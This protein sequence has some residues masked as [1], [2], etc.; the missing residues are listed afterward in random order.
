MFAQLLDVRDQIPRR[1][2]FDGS[3]RRALPRAPLIEEHDAIGRWVVKLPI[4]R[5]H[6]P[7]GST[8]QEHYRL[9]LRIAALLVI[10]LV[11]IRNLQATRIKW[12]D[13]RIKRS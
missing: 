7:A 13:W 2:L 10:D 12:F 11:A 1:V 8:M 3:M 5:R 9:A 6:P 4:L